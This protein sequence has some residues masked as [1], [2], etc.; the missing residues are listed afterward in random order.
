MFTERKLRNNMST[1][2]KQGKNEKQFQKEAV[3]KESC[4][5]NSRINCVFYLRRRTNYMLLKV[6][7]LCSYTISLPLIP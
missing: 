5:L 1:N 4:W 2:L 7:I 6:V 3:Y